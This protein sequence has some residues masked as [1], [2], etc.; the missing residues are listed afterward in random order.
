MKEAERHDKVSIRTGK[1]PRS[2]ARP[3]KTFQNVSDVKN[4]PLA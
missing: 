1:E 2:K 3:V 4:A